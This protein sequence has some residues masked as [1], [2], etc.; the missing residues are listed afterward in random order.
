VKRYRTIVAD[1][2]WTPDLGSTWATRFTDKARPQAQY[3]TMTGERIAA[4]KPPADD[5]A[6]LWLWTLTQHVDWGYRV[7]EA[8]GFG[9]VSMVTWCKPGMGVGQFQCNTEHVLLCR[10]GSRHGNPFGR[11]GGT[12]FEWP[13]G[14]HS[15]KPDAFYDLVE[16]VSPGPYLELFARRARFGWDYWGDQSLGTAEMPEKAA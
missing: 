8:W 16:Q 6:H 13:R 5:Q 12:W 9:V 1:P 11:T 4:L 7:A 14:E 10:K 15:A 3:Q 2:P